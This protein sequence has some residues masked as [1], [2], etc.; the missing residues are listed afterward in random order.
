MSRTASRIA[1][2]SL[3]GAALVL[4]LLLFQPQIGV[5][6]A[7]GHVRIALA[8]DISHRHMVYSAP[9]TLQ[10]SFRMM[11]ESRYIQQYFRRNV[12]MAGIAPAVEDK[13]KEYGWE[14]HN[15]RR[16]EG[17]EESAIHRDWSE[18]LGSGASV[19]ANQFPAKFSFDITTASCGSAAR[20]D[21]VAFNTSAAGGASTPGTAKGKF[22]TNNVT[23]TVTVD[24]VVLTTSATLNTGFFFQTGVSDSADATNLAAAIN[25]N[26]TTVTATASGAST[27]VTAVANGPGG[28]SIAVSTTIVTGFTWSGAT[29]S[30]GTTGQPTIVAY[31][32]LYSGCTGTVP[33]VYWQYDTGGTITTSVEFSGDG[34]QLVFVQNQGGV[35]NLVLLK[36]AANP[37]P[38]NL[39]AVSTS[40]YPT[41]TAPCM[42]TIPLHGNPTDT[43][44]WPFYVFDGPQADSLYVGDDAGMLHKFSPVFN[45][46]PAEVIASWPITI[47][48]GGADLSGP[49]YDG[50]SGN[51]FV[52]DST[53]NVSYVRDVGSTVG[54]CTAPCKG[55][56]V[57]VS[58]AA[59]GT[60]RGAAPMLDAP[61]VDGT[62]QMV[63]VFAPCTLIGDAGGRCG[64]GTAPAQVV[65]Y[66]T[67][68][69]SPVRATVGLSG[70]TNGIHSGTFDNNYYSGV[71][72][73]ARMYAC[74]NPLA[75]ANPTMYIL[76]FNSAGV[77]NTSVITGPAL[78]TSG[79]NNGC[80]PLTEI[81]NPNATLGPADW[82][83]GSVLAS[84]AP[85]GCSGGGC[86]MNFIV[87]AW[88]PDTAY[89]TGQEILDTNGKL[90]LVT[91]P[92]TSS[93]TTPGWNTTTGGL[94]SD[95]STLKWTNQ[96]LLAAANV[97]AAA[98]GT[99]G[100]IVDNTVGT[101]TLAGASQVYYST[102]ANGTC[103]TSGGT[104][105][106]GVQ[107]SQAALH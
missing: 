21:F 16:V 35:A 30:G 85:A 105:G 100:I 36:W 106:C 20:P 37:N 83:Y 67:S 80:S 54:T 61:M 107:A 32:N 75:T 19:G 87:T 2:I 82:V 95:G 81:Y 40:V 76:G 64:D 101:L 44:S 15:P 59:L 72:G 24:G 49:I 25:R 73:S 31:D 38:V 4:V 98:G 28:N 41:C 97:L 63:F 52:T 88:Q 58:A 78:A 43:N 99:S 23:G 5:L 91:T 92:G 66:S 53:W 65:Q 70:T 48:T 34:S 79:T 27:T 86:I 50:V 93:A 69:S 9:R 6:H 13:I 103:A 77:M 1:A 18:N 45:G 22:T 17:D 90:Q 102:L 46:T 56:S 89:V 57:D 26:L 47:N 11:R 29:L 60:V 8:S 84:G 96:G 62:S 104:G 33:S 55:A 7:Q 68:L 51:I 39:T 10:Q 3:C 71:Y 74:G 94:T 14:L 12:A 42:T